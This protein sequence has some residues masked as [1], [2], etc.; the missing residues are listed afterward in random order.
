MPGRCRSGIQSSSTRA[1]TT[2]TTVPNESPVSFGDALVEDVPRVE[3]EVGLD[4]QRHADAVQDQAG[5]ELDQ[6]S[7]QPVTKVAN[8]RSRMPL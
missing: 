4:H 3:A 1:P 7:G 6:A 2:I 8:L 5:E